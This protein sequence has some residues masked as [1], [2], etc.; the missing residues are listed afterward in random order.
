M[1]EEFK[2]QQFKTHYYLF[3]LP[4]SM[5]YEKPIIVSFHLKD[6]PFTSESNHLLRRRVADTAI[7]NCS[8]TISLGTFT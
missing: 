4:Q 5:V 1:K 7:T 8:K 6:N 2:I 3:F